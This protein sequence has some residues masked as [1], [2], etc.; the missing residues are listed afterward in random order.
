MIK[1]Q[2]L[3]YWVSRIE[4]SDNVCH[5]IRIPSTHINN[6]QLAYKHR[7][8]SDSRSIYLD[9]ILADYVIRIASS[10]DQEA[11]KVCTLQRMNLLSHWIPTMKSDIKDKPKSYCRELRA[12]IKFHETDKHGSL[13]RYIF[14]SLLIDTT[15]ISRH[16]QTFVIR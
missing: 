11:T 6:K 13:N 3:G 16:S 5:V 2:I 14:S 10:Q 12:C 8:N 4:Y 9:T 15:L 7:N 1:K